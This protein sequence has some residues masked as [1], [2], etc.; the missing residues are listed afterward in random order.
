MEEGQR[1]EQEK[2]YSDWENHSSIPKSFTSQWRVVNAKIW[3]V[4]GIEW[5]FSDLS[6]LNDN[7]TTNMTLGIWWKRHFLCKNCKIGRRAVNLL[8][9]WHN[10]TSLIMISQQLQLSSLGMHTIRPQNILFVV[11]CCLYRYSQ[12]PTLSCWTID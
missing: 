10:T 11:H 3:A 6:T 5:Q 4:Q 1:S 2:R 7:C 9:P 12:E 8:S